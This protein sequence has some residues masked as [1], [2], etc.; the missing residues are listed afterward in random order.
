MKSIT[1]VGM[2]VV[3]CVASGT[4]LAKT[5]GEVRGIETAPVSPLPKASTRA[6]SVV[7][8]PQATSPAPAAAPVYQ[9]VQPVA[10]QPVETAPRKTV[11]TE[12]RPTNYMAT[13]AVSAFMGAVAGALIGGAIYYLDDQNNPENIAYWAAGG[14]LVGTGIGVVNV[15]VQES[16]ADAAVASRRLP[17]DPAPTVRVAL[18]QTR[19]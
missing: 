6:D 16:R 3:L 9:P 15:L 19:F 17:S 5:G 12:T 7:V 11:V 18:F 10:A 1:A 14:V 8:T 2:A 13:I 4:A